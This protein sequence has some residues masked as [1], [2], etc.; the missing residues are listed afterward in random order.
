MVKK[1][2]WGFKVED[3]GNQETRLW[4]NKQGGQVTAGNME[5]RICPRGGKEQTQRGSSTFSSSIGNRFWWR[6]EGRGNFT[7]LYGRNAKV[8]EETRHRR[9]KYHVMIILRVR[10]KG[11]TGE[12]WSM[13]PLMNTNDT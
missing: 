10:F 7:C 2:Q 5:E 8:W 9:D 3:G 13:L 4:S 1:I 6:V 12:K 11:E